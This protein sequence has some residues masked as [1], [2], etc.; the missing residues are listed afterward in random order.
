MKQESTALA[1]AARVSDSVMAHL[2]GLVR[3]DTGAAFEIPALLGRYHIVRLIG[4]GAA[5]RVYLA[6]D[7]QLGRRVAI[8]VLTA[9]ANDAYVRR[10][11]REASMAAGLSHPGIVTIHEVSMVRRD[12]GTP[13]HFLVMDHYERTLEQALDAATL[14]RAAEGVQFAHDHGIVHCDLKPGNILLDRDG[15]PVISDFGLARREFQKSEM[16]QDGMPIG[17]PSYMSPEQV[18]GRLDR[19]GPA[20]D[21][22]S[23]GVILYRAL[24]GKL[25]FEGDNHAEL[26]TAILRQD[27]IP[28]RRHAPSISR[29][30]EIV[31]LKAIEKDPAQR[32][33]SVAEFA[34]DLQR[35]RAGEPIYAAPTSTLRRK[36]RRALRGRAPLVAAVLALLAA[37]AGVAYLAVQRAEEVA[38]REEAERREVERLRAWSRARPHLIEGQRLLERIQIRITKPDCTHRERRELGAM[39]RAEFERALREFPDDPEALLGIAQSHSLAG[40]E[41]EAL[42]AVDRA[43]A[44]APTMARP[45]VDRIRLRIPQYHHLRHHP[46]GFVTRKTEASDEIEAQIHADLAT[47]RRLSADPLELTAVN[48]MLDFAEAKYLD[49]ANGLKQYLAGEATDP[50]A[51]KLLGHSFVHLNRY[52]EAVEAL[53]RAYGYDAGDAHAAFMLG[54]AYLNQ[55]KTDEAIPILSRAVEIRPGYTSAFL[56]RGIALIQKRDYDA[57]LQDFE[58]VARIDPDHRQVYYYRGF[59]HHSAHDHELAIEDYTRAH[60][61]N[62]SW[63]EPLRQRALLQ[64]HMQRHPEAAR[65]ARAVLALNPD[66][67]VRREMQTLLDRP[68]EEF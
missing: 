54:S 49:C 27:P 10:F 5:G 41:E 32:Y 1:P 12:D 3:P 33:A 21:Q 19:V 44:V 2:A 51:W 52:A 22:Y 39:A 59:I 30:M 35:A 31:C 57:A 13:I 68:G 40:E 55:Q 61:L 14:E 60:E 47:I 17:T 56:N 65:D 4:E 48:A 20:S 29:E 42:A 46:G 58:T 25:P 43:I 7:R 6:E 26:Y 50:L 9:A 15:R 63:I 8:K 18:A 66:P 24:T 23:L 28:P 37:V 11:H 16:T 45:Y 53:E 67:A 34:D 62:P 64:N 36:M 38:A